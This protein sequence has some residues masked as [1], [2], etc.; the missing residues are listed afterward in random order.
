MTQDLFTRTRR[1]VAPHRILDG[2]PDF[3][4]RLIQLIDAIAVLT[5]DERW[6]E[7][8]E[9]FE[10]ART[11]LA[12]PS[13]A[14]RARTR[15]VARIDDLIQRVGHEVV[16][17][18]RALPRKPMAALRPPSAHATPRKPMAVLRLPKLLAARVVRR[19]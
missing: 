2:I 18:L 5:G 14:A 1:Y 19:R 4:Y 7:T 3:L 6:N 16:A 15:E 13:S 10:K 9:K 12:A 11:A 8:L 17:R